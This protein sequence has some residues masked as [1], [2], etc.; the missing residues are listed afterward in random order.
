MSDQDVRADDLSQ[1]FLKGYLP[2]RFDCERVEIGEVVKFP[3]G[4]SRE[5][6]FVACELVRGTAREERK[7]VF[8][9]DFPG[10]SICPMKLRTEF[11]VY[12]RLQTSNVPVAKTF[13]FE[14]DPVRLQGQRPFYIR[15]QVEGSWEIPHIVDTDPAYAEMRIAVAK[16]HLKALALVHT[17]DWQA[18]GFGEIFDVPPSPEDSARTLIESV[19]RELS[20][21]QIEPFPL[22]TE[23]REWM[24]DNAPT[25]VSRV[26]LLKGTNGY[27][28]EIFKDGKV[29]ALSDWELARLGDPAY[30]WA[31]IQDLIG[32]ITVDGETVWGLQP[33]LD[34]YEELCGI[35]VEAASVI[36]Y[37]MLYSLIG[38]MFCHNAAIPVTKGTDLSARLCW[39]STEVLYRMQRT[40]AAI[41]GV[42]RKMT[43]VPGQL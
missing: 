30:D 28:E 26:S 6:W 37:R 43:N 40:M 29:V 10:G 17:C 1:G 8:R 16:E 20:E 27:G 25:V 13:G 35:H 15:E 2:E 3:R 24:L 9:R 5:T 39:P 31:Q 18:L 11:E 14:D 21:F 7:L 12:D 4:S 36:Y 38:V 33:A 22:F 23:A 19:A 34:Y 41:V 32:D 42:G